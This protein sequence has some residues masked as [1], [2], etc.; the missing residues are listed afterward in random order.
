MK[1]N[2]TNKLEDKE[3]CGLKEEIIKQLKSCKFEKK[4][5]TRILWKSHEQSARNTINSVTNSPD[6]GYNNK[7]KWQNTHTRV[8]KIKH[9][10]SMSAQ[11][12]T[13]NAVAVV[14]KQ[15]LAEFNPLHC[16]TEVPC[17]LS[18]CWPGV[19]SGL[20][21]CPVSQHSSLFKD[22]KR[23]SLNLLQFFFFFF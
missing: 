12:I 9:S 11:L 15:L 18:G 10:F 16:K 7:L 23:V 4:S 13:A 19:L 14:R 2:Y 3:V 22:S 20:W 1:D 17:F 5:K 6:M 8:C 21:V